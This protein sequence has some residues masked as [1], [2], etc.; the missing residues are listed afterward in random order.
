M[1][2]A[3]LSVG[4]PNLSANMDH[5][6]GQKAPNSRVA[7]VT[8]ATGQDGY[9]LTERLLDEGWKVHALVRRPEALESLVQS[10]EASGTLEVHAVDLLEPSKLL[11]LVADIRPDEFYNLAGCSSVSTSFSDPL[12]TWQTNAGTVALLLECVRTRST[13]TRF[14]QASSSEMFG[15]VPGGNVV[16]NE[17]SRIN[18]QSPYASAKAAAHLACSSYRK[19]YNLRISCGI[20]F[21]HESRRRSDQFLSRKVVDHVQTIRRLYPHAL[22]SYPPLAMGNLKAKRDW[23]FAPDYVGGILSIARQINVRSQHLGTQPDPDEGA[24]YRDYVLGTGRLHAV[25]QLV[26]RA[27]ALKG[28]D[29]EWHLEG[30]NPTKWGAYFST[31]GLPAV[32]VDPALLRPADP[33]AIKADAF[34]AH[35]EL[36][37]TPRTGLDVFLQDMLK[38]HSR[39]TFL[40]EERK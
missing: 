13:H 31:T 7:M 11:D 29:L 3:R 17:D 5:L 12:G 21:N 16:H 40:S 26:D 25:W 33:M 14:Y 34:R 37:W 39:L 2:Y 19:A 9:L 18:P 32:V 38:E 23:G 8:G 20:L 28:F 24:Y 30:A 22:S 36:G 4:K 10:R 6:M 35:E 1:Q 15:Y 27:F